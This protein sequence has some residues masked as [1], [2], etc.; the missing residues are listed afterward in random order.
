MVVRFTPITVFFLF[1][2]F[3]FAYG[4]E[5]RVNSSTQFTEIGPGSALVTWQSCSNHENAIRFR[6][7]GSQEWIIRNTWDQTQF[8]LTNLKPR[9]H[10]EI[11]VRECSDEGRD[12][13]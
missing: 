7:L 3:Q 5:T 2:F 10:Y 6:E 9:T 4:Q 8:R 12:A 11:Q 13:W 1:N